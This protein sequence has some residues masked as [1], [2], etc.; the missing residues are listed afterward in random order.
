M[1]LSEDGSLAEYDGELK[2]P[3]GTDYT[4]W[5]DIICEAEQYAFFTGCIRFLF[6]K[7][8]SEGL[9]WD[10]KDFDTKWSKV[11]DYFDENGVKDTIISIIKFDSISK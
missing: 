3:N 11:L 1:I 6:R 2:R 9:E 8:K 7:G 4:T 10:K 5:Q